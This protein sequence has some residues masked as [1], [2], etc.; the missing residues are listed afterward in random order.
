MKKLLLIAALKLLLHFSYGQTLKKGNLLGLHVMTIELKPNVTMEQYK[1]FFITR[2]IPAYEKE[3]KGAKGYL[4]KGVR[5]ESNNS[6]GTIWLF[7]SEQARNKYFGPDETPNNLGKAAI[8]KL[9]PIEK[10]LEEK[11]GTRTSKY[12][13]WVVQ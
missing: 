5:G 1:T 10:E 7:E 13:D 4:V 12:T 8:D 3:F 9:N 6:F 2:V 11:L